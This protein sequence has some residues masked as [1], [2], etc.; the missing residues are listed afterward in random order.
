[1]NIYKKKL[2][3]ILKSFDFLNYRHT[4]FK[5]NRNK[6]WNNLIFQISRMTTILCD[7]G[8]TAIRIE[9]MRRWQV[10]VIASSYF[11]ALIR[12]PMSSCFVLSIWPLSRRL[13]MPHEF[14]M[15]FMSRRLPGHAWTMILWGQRKFIEAVWQRTL[16]C[17]KNHTSSPNESSF[18]NELS[19]LKESIW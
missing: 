10:L 1:M 18:K 9:P 16:S 7:E 11:H 14:S 13:M 6:S 4:S 12:A 8:C 5:S 17:M 15:G 2:T 3:S 19:S